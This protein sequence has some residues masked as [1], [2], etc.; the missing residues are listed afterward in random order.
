M[1]KKTL[2][3]QAL[4][5]HKTSV[6]LLP[7]LK[8][9]EHDRDRDKQPTTNHDDAMNKWWNPWKNTCNNYGIHG[10]EAYARDMQ[11]LKDRN[12]LALGERFGFNDLL[13]DLSEPWPPSS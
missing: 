5:V 4:S 1:C 12:R 9:Q 6:S 8:V 3:E 11:H 7:I 10:V 13:M 2:L